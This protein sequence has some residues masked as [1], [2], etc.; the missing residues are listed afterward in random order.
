MQMRS[1][2]GKVRGL[3]S[4]KSGVVHWWAQRITAVALVPL[5]IWFV[6]AAIGLVGADYG[7][8]QDWISLHG[9]LV[10]L[11]AFTAVLFHH[12]QL[13]LQVVIE[14]YIHGEALK[15]ASIVAV[16]FVAAMCTISIIFAALRV[17][18]AG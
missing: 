17:A 10:L 2:L 6:I 12:A 1:S 14:D 15:V 8:F 18:F 13:G 9:N 3:G 7:T 16:K 4:T 11:I 5:S